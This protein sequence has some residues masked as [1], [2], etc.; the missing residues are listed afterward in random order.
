MNINNFFPSSS[1]SSSSVP[2]IDQKII[3][4]CFARSY[5]IVSSENKVIHLISK[6]AMFPIWTKFRFNFL[7]WMLKNYNTENSKYTKMR[8]D[9]L[10]KKN[11][12]VLTIEKDSVFYS[13][14]EDKNTK[15]IF[16]RY[17]DYLIVYTLPLSYFLNLWNITSDN[18]FVYELFLETRSNKEKDFNGYLNDTIFI[19]Q[20]FDWLNIKEIFKSVKIN[21]SK[22]NSSH[23]D[24]LST[25][26][27]NLSS[28]LFNVGV[29][30]DN[31]IIYSS[32]DNLK[33]L[34]KKNNVVAKSDDCKALDS[35]SQY[36]KIND[37]NKDEIMFT[38]WFNTILGKFKLALAKYFTYL[39]CIDIA[40]H[41]LENKLDKSISN[42]SRYDIF[43]FIH[44]IY[45]KNNIE[46]K[47][48]LAFKDDSL[49]NNEESVYIINMYKY[50]EI[51]LLEQEYKE[52]NKFILNLLNL[53]KIII[54]IENKF[55]ILCVSKNN[56]LVE[57]L[58][59]LEK[60]LFNLM[61]EV[62]EN[63][64]ISINTKS[65]MPFKEVDETIKHNKKNERFKKLERKNNKEFNKRYFSTFSYRAI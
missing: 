62:H 26:E 52:L 25:V 11:I 10:S 51:S 63:L 29:F 55:H 47:T 49:I 6:A 46:F 53:E 40:I 20:D 50:K 45:L 27:H 44:K 32:F 18:Y 35:Y 23:R 39:Y 56:N 5:D 13:K 22:G 42:V 14:I 41:S 30:F 2:L 9:P 60:E 59:E 33:K 43:E 21:I 8:F 16:Q 7:G 3:V 61:N 58:R 34:S 64:R 4:A 1:S 48:S 15:Y 17:D 24:I 57:I 65:L 36:I 38:L 12:I 28:F 54:A 19:F 31:H 37:Q